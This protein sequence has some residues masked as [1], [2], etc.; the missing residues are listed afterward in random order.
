[1]SHIRRSGSYS[2]DWFIRNKI[3]LRLFTDGTL[4]E[5]I[6]C[7]GTYENYGG[8]GSMHGLALIIYYHKIR[9]G[10]ILICH[11]TKENSISEEKIRHG[12]CNLLPLMLQT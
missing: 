11:Q 5:T 9:S 12:D 7:M 1:M 6:P 8:Y 3:V 2:E 4:Q 10:K